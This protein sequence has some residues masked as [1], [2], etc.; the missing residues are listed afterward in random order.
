MG[1]KQKLFS[2]HGLLTALECTSGSAQ[3]C[4]ISTQ[5]VGKMVRSNNF[6]KIWPEIFMLVSLV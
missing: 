3:S 4:Q 1:F 5:K 6:W 2:G